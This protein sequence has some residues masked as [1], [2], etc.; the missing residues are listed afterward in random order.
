MRGGRRATP[1][2]TGV[3]VR[4]AT[5]LAMA[6][7][8]ASCDGSRASESPDRPGVAARAH[9]GS[10]N[11]LQ[12]ET[13]PY[14][15]QHAHNP[16]DWYPWG[17]EAL[18]RARREDKPIFLSVGY[19]TCYWCHVMERR[20]FAD[21]HIA[22]MMNRWFV[23]IKVDREERP[24]LDQIYM[25]ATQLMNRHGGWPNSVFLT[26]DLQP[27]YAGTYFPPED[28]DGRPGFTRVLTALQEHW[29]ERR[30]QVEEVAG[31]VTARIRQ[32]HSDL[33]ALAPVDP[34]SAL[35]GRA[36]EAT[37][38][39]YDT[40]NGGFGGAPKFPPAMRLQ[41][42]LDA[43][44]R[45]GD[46]EALRIVSHTLDA[47]AR[48]GIHDQIG[49]GFHRYSTDAQWRVPHFEKMLYNQAQ[50]TRVYLRAY[51]L[52]DAP[53]WRRVAADILRYVEREMTAPAGA[54][55]SALDAETD[56]VEGKYYVWT[57]AQ[58][59][60]E[61]GAAAER[62][63]EHYQLAPV[64]ETEG[65]HV[66]YRAAPAAT[67]P[68][69]DAGPEI[70]PEGDFAEERRR[71]LRR[72]SQRRYPLLDDKVITAW[73]G[74]MIAACAEA[75]L[76]L[77][78]EPYRLAAERAADF[79]LE[80]LATPAGALRRVY[81]Q[82]A[83]KHEGYLEDYAHFA[84]GLLALHAATG[85][86]R[87]LDAATLVTD[88]MVARFWDAQTDGFYYSEEG[89]ADLIVRVKEA[90]DAAL[91]AANAVATRCLTAL[92][93]RTGRADLR[94]KA[95]R[96]LRA[97]GAG[98][99]Q[100]PAAYTAMMGAAWDQLT[101]VEQ[102]AGAAA[103][104]SAK[105]PA[106]AATSGVEAIVTARAS[107]T[108]ERV[109]PGERFEAFVDIDI[110]DGWHLNANPPSEGW[111]IP[112]TLTV[113]NLDLPIQVEQPRYPPG[114]RLPVPALAGSLD[115]YEGAVRLSSA[116]QL[117]TSAVAGQQGAVRL[118]VQ[119]QACDEA[120]VCLQPAEW[121][122]EVSVRIANRV[123]KTGR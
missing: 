26:P 65:G 22:A 92:A 102:A 101:D 122:G 76:A 88:Q 2:P 49:G 57:E 105:P 93:R 71:L 40:A 41:L 114:T 90:T 72:R 111:L 18:E 70:R 13:S 1:G 89:D 5:V 120:G 86:E 24:D 52:T 62:F 17:P 66:I 23:N 55:Y 110:A 63:F 85:E 34:D 12:Y 60:D 78:H 119:Y 44:E 16:V 98:M 38:R 97:F 15:L 33:P 59:R 31:Q 107:L 45:A 43:W 48:G 28:E 82:G 6:A 116:L 27:F 75:Y 100:H 91:P 83:A 56:A 64:A 87:W 46:D 9:G 108:R 37:K 53:R 80:H 94:Q 104:I 61:L 96:T 123:S 81:R 69:A 7:V 20:V 25:T 115:V 51:R 50:L 103:P 14:L 74:M 95:A 67:A 113:N 36:L 30:A 112:T 117:S 118:I 3:Y 8:A 54:F 19:S 42:L 10:A 39:Q 121:V 47:M 79:I 68:G 11:R 4:I 73:N 58:L 32:R 99:A 21:P 77:G 109:A 29:T 35:I 84:D 106:V